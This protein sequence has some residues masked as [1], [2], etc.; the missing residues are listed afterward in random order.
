MSRAVKLRGMNTPKR[1]VSLISSATEMLFLLGLGKQVVGVSHECDYPPEIA[2]LPRLTRS[3]VDATATSRTIDDQVRVFAA[4][5]QALYAIDSPELAR[6]KPDLIITQAQCDVCAVRY[7]DV[8]NAVRN[9]PALAS[10]EILALNPKRLADVLEDLRRVAEAVDCKGLADDVISALAARAEHVCKTSSRLS[11]EDR[12][13]VALL[14]WIDPPMLAGNWT[15]EL[16]AW[17]GGLDGLPQDGRHSSYKSWQQIATFD[18]EVVVIMP[19]GFDVYRTIAEAQV[20]AELPEWHG[21]SAVRAGKVFAADGNAYFNR[22]G[23]R[24]VDSLEILAHLFHPNLFVAPAHAAGSWKRLRT[25][26]KR[27]VVEDND[28]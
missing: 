13:R 3:L 19:C 7:D 22:S 16:V 4:G 18:P 8:V 28:A 21:L 5:Q 17:A 10:A 9:E 2:G 12:P 11:D 6:L 15:P 24:L 25:A 27:L 1:I 23:P 20:L 26:G 14:E